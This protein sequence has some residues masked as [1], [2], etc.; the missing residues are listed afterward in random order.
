MD[1][2]KINVTIL[3]CGGSDGVP[4]IR[5]ECHVCKSDEAVN[6]RTRASILITIFNESS[7]YNII[8][9]T[10]PDLRQQILREKIK[11]I[12]A[13]IYTHCHFDHIGGLGDLKHLTNGSPIPMFADPETVSMIK[14][15]FLYAFNDANPL[16]PPL[17]KPYIFNGSFSI[18]DENLNILMQNSHSAIIGKNFTI[19][20]FRQIHG[21]YFSY[22]FRIGD[23]A[24][25]TDVSCLPEEAY[26]VLHGVKIWI[27]DCVRYYKSPTHFC[28]ENTIRAINRVG[29]EKAILTH[30]C[31]DI[32]YYELLRM[33]PHNIVPAYDGMQISL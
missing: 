9:D 6:K 25:S 27:I 16:Y 26:S 21:K 8:I 19:Y 13:V 30:M 10:G 32:E 15:S 31:H 33:L 14:K 7:T 29:P 11:H 20:P 1:I 2:T 22:G 5:C 23:F 28:I 24:Y 18:V 3:G 4:Q 12:D 17:L